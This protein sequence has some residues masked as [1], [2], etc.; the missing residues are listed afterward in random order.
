MVWSPCNLKKPI[1]HLRGHPYSLCGV[2][3]VP[4]TPQV[5]TADV[6]G[7]LRLW[8]LRNFRSFQTFG[9]RAT[10]YGDL[11]TLCAMPP[12]KQIVTG[13][14]TIDTYT[15]QEMRTTEKRRTMQG[16]LIA[17]LHN[18]QHNKILTISRTSVISWDATGGSVSRVFQG[19]SGPEV[20]AACLDWRKQKLYL[21]DSSGG[22]ACCNATSGSELYQAQ[23]HT[24]A[25]KHICPWSG[26]KCFVSA[27]ADGLVL[28]QEEVGTPVQKMQVIY[29]ANV[30][31]EG[32]LCMT[33][34]D[35]LKLLACGSGKVVH[36]FCLRRLRKEGSLESLNSTVQS[37]DFSSSGEFLVIGEDAGFISVW[38][39]QSLEQLHSWEFY[40]CWENI[41]QLASLMCE[42]LT[43]EDVQNKKQKAFSPSEDPH[44]MKFTYKRNI[45][46]ST[47][48]DGQEL[49]LPAS[50]RAVKI[51]RF[52]GSVLQVYTADERGYLRLWDL[53]KVQERL[54][55][56]PPVA[57]SGHQETLRFTAEDQDATSPWGG[58]SATS[59]KT[60]RGV[61][62]TRYRTFLT[63]PRSDWTDEGTDMP[64]KASVSRKRRDGAQGKANSQ[65]FA[66][67][68]CAEVNL[69]H[70]VRGHDGAVMAVELC[71]TEDDTEANVPQETEAPGRECHQRWLLSYGF[72][73]VVKV[74]SL[75]L[76]QLGQL[77][78]EVSRTWS[79]LGSSTMERQRIALKAAALNF[80]AI[81]DRLARSSSTAPGLL[82]EGFKTDGGSFKPPQALVEERR[83]TKLGGPTS[84]SQLAAFHLKT[85]PKRQ[86]P[87]TSAEVTAA[88]KFEHLLDNLLGT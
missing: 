82:A 55:V 67:G 65:G 17:A 21:G 71:N 64:E 59:V 31:R 37:M 85:W 28:V 38:R 19:I 7:T 13:G 72:D 20:T 53:S 22:I 41:S 46:S 88:I 3:V 15:C 9:G 58:L 74:W 18:S 66:A 36:F 86:N 70:E 51:N 6:S 84:A 54:I 76:R 14:S 45:F 4:G 80:Q 49:I 26:T 11:S 60:R 63:Q 52:S 69:L 33:I 83:A 40:Y 75:K 10:C 16:E 34:S 50:T 42:G 47:D 68:C 32:V 35:C 57:P 24:A 79:P 81:G 30:G 77:T 8:D 1:C 23:P 5:V 87:L 39:L 44:T 61:T 2:V 62:A 73:R 56:E 27:S 25:V 78:S 48:D 43:L 29:Q 12:Y